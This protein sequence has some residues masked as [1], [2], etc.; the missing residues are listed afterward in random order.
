MNLVL[1]SS[2]VSLPPAGVKG[3]AGRA[4]LPVKFNAVKAQILKQPMNSGIRIIVLISA[5]IVVIVAFSLSGQ[6]HPIF[7]GP[8]GLDQPDVSGPPNPLPSFHMTVTPTEVR[9]RPGDPID[10]EVLIQPENGFNESVDLELEVDAG[11]V[12]GGTYHAGVMKPPYPKTYKY[13]V[14]V[15]QQA[16]APLTVNGT[17]RATG[18]GHSERVDLALFIEP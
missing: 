5:S 15:P 3:P 9:A 16:P 8:T 4:A 13:R 12:F 1:H 2:E 18:G 10:C 6:V 14:V 17:L 7:D 11:P